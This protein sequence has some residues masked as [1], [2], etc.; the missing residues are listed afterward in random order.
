MDPRTTISST[1]LAFS[2]HGHLLAGTGNKGHIFAIDGE[3]EYADLLKTTA[4]QVTAFANAPHGGLYAATSNL[5]KIFC[6]G[7][8]LRK[9]APTR[10]MSSMRTFFSLGAGRL[11]WRGARRT[12]CSQR[13][14][15]QSRPQLESLAKNRRA[16]GCRSRCPSRQIC[17]MESG[18]E[19]RRP[20]AA[21]GQHGPELSAEKRRTRFRR[22]CGANRRALPSLPKSSTGDSS[23]SGGSNPPHFEAPPPAIHDRSSIGVKW[24]VHDEN[25]DEMIYSV[26]YRGDKEQRWLLLKGNITDKFYC[27]DASLLPDGGYTAKIL[28]SDA[29]SHSPHDALTAERESARFEVDTTPPQIENLHASQEQGRIHVTFRASDSF[30]SLK[31]AEYSVDAG[32]WQFI[33]PVDQLSDAKTE[34][35]DF[36][37]AGPRELGLSGVSAS[38]PDRR[39]IA[40]SAA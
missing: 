28:A 21:P 4:S 8:R 24:N 7:L 31:R 27:F 25:E 35:Y 17:A 15:G 23:G 2:N 26:Y 18:V 9:K 5:G 13:Q 29:P 30:S 3:D 12:V 22:G 34:N 6:W 1:P 36:Q 16:K 37:T 32:D 38:T 33:E 40:G 39:Q 20:R 14:R 19:I 11:S 10:A